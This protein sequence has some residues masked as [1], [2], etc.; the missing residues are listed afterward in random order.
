[1]SFWAVMH[2]FFGWV[3]LGAGI[4]IAALCVYLFTPNI[5]LPFI[6]V[7]D[8]IRQWAIIVA[9]VSGTATLIYGKAFA[10]GTRYAVNAIAAQN[11]GMVVEVQK[12][13]SKV[14]DCGA[15]GLTWDTVS[16]VCR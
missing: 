5:K 3:G 6:E 12:Q 2:L 11:M 9:A 1:M 14:D 8:R 10:D 15:R 16:G 13:K 4:S 7:D